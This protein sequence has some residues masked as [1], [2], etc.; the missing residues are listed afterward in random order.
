MSAKEKGVVHMPTGMTN[1]LLV[2]DWWRR[3]LPE[4]IYVKML[5]YSWKS[6][7][8]AASGVIRASSGGSHQHGELL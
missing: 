6:Q 8:G 5:A 7:V 3:T 2:S 1:V 4:A